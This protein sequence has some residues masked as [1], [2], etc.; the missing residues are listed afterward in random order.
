[1]I[2]SDKYHQTGQTPLPISTVRSIQLCQAIIHKIDENSS[3]L[4]DSTQIKSNQINS[5][6]F[7]SAASSTCLSLPIDLLSSAFISKSFRHSN[8]TRS[9]EVIAQSTF[10]QPIQSNSIQSNPIQSVL[11]C[12]GLFFSK[13]HPAI[14]SDAALISTIPTFPNR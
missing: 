2:E 7:R 1:M 14:V 11:S 12:A 6:I 5:N 13:L 3:L 9:A 10:P 8:H 4:G